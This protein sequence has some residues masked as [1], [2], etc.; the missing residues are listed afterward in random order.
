MLSVG[1]DWRSRDAR[2]SADIGHQ[3]HRLRNT[4]P[5]VT[6]GSGV[7]VVNIDNGFGAGYF[8]H[9]VCRG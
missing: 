2:I 9:L 8:A 6:L 5:N 4:R 1:L 7:T 3:E